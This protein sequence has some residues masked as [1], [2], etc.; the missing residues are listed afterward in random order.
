MECRAVKFSEFDSQMDNWDNYIDRLTF[1]FEA[2]GIVLDSQKRANFYTVCGSKVF[3]TL[4]A[5]IS[6]KKSKDVSFSDI[7]VI[8]T[9]HYSPKP[10]E[11]SV[12]Y[13]FYKR[14]QIAGESAAEYIA[15]L[16]KISTH[17]NFSDLERMLR[18]RLVCGMNNHRLQYDLLKTD[19]LTYDNVV[20]AML[21]SERS[22]KDVRMILNANENTTSIGNDS[23]LN[24]ASMSTS[25]TTSA[26]PMDINAVQPQNNIKFCYRC[27]DRHNGDCRFAKTACRYCKKIGHIEKICIAKKR[28]MSKKINYTEEDETYVQLNGVYNVGGAQVRV[29]AYNITVYINDI[30][31]AMQVDSGAGFSILNERT[32]KR[33]CAAQSHLALRTA[34][35]NL[36]TWTATPVTVLGQAIVK[37][38]FRDIKCV[39]P[40]IIA[41]GQGPNL[42]GRDWFS[43]LKITIN[44]NVLSSSHVSITDQMLNKHSEVFKEGLGTYRGNPVTINLKPDAT[45]RFLK[46]RPVPFAIKARVEKEIDRLK[47]EG[48]LR[49]VS[50][51]QWATP[52]VPI[53]KKSGEIRLCGD[54]RSTVNQATESDTYPMPTANEV[55]AIIAGGRYFTT[56]DLERAYTQVIVDEDTAKLLTLNTSKGL[57][58]VHRLAFGVKACPG[59][60]QRLM[61]ALLAG[62]P[63]VAVLI[64]DIIISGHTR[65]DMCQ[66]LDAVL[67]RIKKAGLR[68]NANKCKVARECVEFLGFVIDADGIHPA[69]SKVESILKTPEPQNIRELQAFLGLYN[70]YE[71]FIQHKATILEPLHRLLDKSHKWQWTERE[72]ESFDT[73]K[74]ILSSDVTLVHYDLNKPL[75]L[76]CDSSEYGVG[77]VLAHVMQDG[78]ERPVAMSSR[79]LHAH[80]RKYSQLDKEATAI[81]FGIQKFHNYLMGRHFSIVTDHKPLV[82]LFD[83]QK[84]IPNILSPRLTRIAIVLTS[85]SYNIFYKPG[86]QIGNAD[87]LSRWPQPVPEEPEKQL[88]DI[89][90]MAEAPEDFPVDVNQ[91][92]ILTKRDKILSQVLYCVLSGWPAK[93][94]ELQLRK[95]W[96]HRTELSIHEGCLLLGN[97]VVVPPPLHK[98]VLRALHKAHSG[99]VQTKALAR[100][101]VW[102]PELNDDIEAMVN[103]CTKCLENKHMPPK[104]T[105]EWVVPTRPWSRINIDFAGPFQN[106]IFLIIVDSYSRWP[107]AFIVNNMT[108]DTVIR[109]LRMLFA[110]HGLCETLVS[111]N[112][113][114][115]VSA[116][117]KR[118][119]ASNKIKHITTAPY[120][121]ATNGLAERM[122]Q[123]IKDKLRKMEDIP[124]DVKIPNMLLGLRVTPCAGTGKSPSELLMNRRLRT[125]LDSIHPVNKKHNRIE[126]QI[127]N[128]NEQKKQR[129]TNL[130]QEVMYRN[131]GTGA[132]WLP[133]MVTSRGGPS[134]Y[135]VTTE[136]GDIINRHIDQLIKKKR[137]NSGTGEVEQINR[138]LIQDD[139]IHIENETQGEEQVWN[140]PSASNQAKDEIIQI[141][142]SEQ[143]AEMLGIPAGAETTYSGGKLKNKVCSY[144]KSPYARS[145]AYYIN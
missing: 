45:P 58:T 59:I 117:M 50:Y 81:L 42:V 111:D 125:L 75:V 91:I 57:Y 105:C 53:V 29:P 16:R 39:L 114:A 32:W 49:P 5:L 67:E 13:Q 79:T 83:P 60:F 129:D 55:F 34:P 37:V 43:A 121:P 36:R 28:A 56:L 64:D 106:K 134:S 97:R 108:T 109:H 62:I 17:C 47:A 11:I 71:R 85:H 96:L 120:H 14:D 3:D 69:P 130:G 135:Q 89:L 12:S 31:V 131:Y 24:T 9:K 72:Q 20:E 4:L 10:N 137:P 68:L 122:V 44:I 144:A 142:S 90:L 107:E 102:W 38:T 87:G 116:E 2:N 139:D 92:E 61:T 48:V 115:F 19:N 70:F 84:P 128:N 123:T 8:L 103:N 52:V 18:D 127:N 113:T 46:A 118:F 143:W 93:V 94:T 78:Q 95:Y 98:D 74:H 27:G 7:V 66:R 1:C 82:S 136:D 21:S 138:E 77:A 25:V 101:Y 80:E 6:P 133:G 124:W 104:T 51:S 41:K 141:P 54:Y 65:A 86:K 30:S 40:I 33:L 15:Q 63:G 112:G 26:E 23:K 35:N 76:T 119:L 145:S 22:G 132:R 73:A 110:T 100:S 140:E 88:C 126:R 99:I